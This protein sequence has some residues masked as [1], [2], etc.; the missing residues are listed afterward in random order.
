[1]N[2]KCDGLTCA[3]AARDGVICPVD[4]CDYQT[5]V[6]SPSPLSVSF[7]ARVAKWMMAC[8]SPEVCRDG[9]ERNHRFLEEA[10]ELVQS[11][12]C[13][14]S[15]AHQ[16]VDY[17]FGRPVGEPVQ[18]MG[19]VMVTL[20]AL[21]CAH[22]LG[23]MPAAETELARVWTKIDQIRA[24]QAAKPKH[25]PLPEHA[26]TSISSDY[27]AGMNAAMEIVGNI[28]QSEAGLFDAA[29]SGQRG[30]DRST[31]LYDA[32]HSIRKAVA[33]GPKAVA[34]TS[35][36]ELMIEGDETSACI[37][38]YRSPDE[39]H[40]TLRVELAAKVERIARIMRKLLT[41]LPFC[42]PDIKDLEQA[43]TSL[44][45]RAHSGQ[46]THLKTFSDIKKIALSAKPEE[47]SAALGHIVRLCINAGAAA[48]AQ[49][50]WTEDAKHENGN[51]ECLCVEC[52]QS[53]IGHKRRV[54]CKA[55]SSLLSPGVTVD[56]STELRVAVARSLVEVTNRWI[57]PN[58]P[59]GR[60]LET[61]DELDDRERRLNLDYADAAIA[62]MT[63]RCVTVG[64]HGIYIASKTRH[65]DRWI[66]LRE[67][68]AP[69][70]STWIDEAAPGASANLDDLWHRCIAESSSCAVLI[71]YR[72]PEDILKGAWIEMGAAL[73]CGIPVFAVG[74]RE[75]TVSKCRQLRHFDTINEAFEAARVLAAGNR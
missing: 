2:D 22:D 41:D 53:F 20:A 50:N 60:Q 34:T 11:L 64:N 54:I 32:Y 59:A 23:M 31:A 5:G 74:M 4:S 25:S 55:C 30:E 57:K 14:A 51:Y 15:E 52:D 36:P 29:H 62:T 7:Q 17:T 70:I 37:V 21:A 48:Q 71:V 56:T 33:A 69:I 47:I 72:E 42:D 75:Y 45:S 24:K 73:A 38:P 8:F 13:S 6:R 66:K 39:A 67:A 43:A 12:G 16:L 9:R 65:A 1:M 27:L 35:E 28:R 68:G 46:R 40:A 58:F 44:R 63:G 19:G 61:F 3:A 10:L 18:E 26:Q 49:R